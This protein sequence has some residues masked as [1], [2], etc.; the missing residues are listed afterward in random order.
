VQL[1]LVNDSMFARQIRMF[2]IM[3]LLV[4]MSLA[5]INLVKIYKVLNTHRLL[6][7]KMTLKKGKKQ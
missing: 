5:V 7:K 1:L 3:K 4:K 6:Q 2:N